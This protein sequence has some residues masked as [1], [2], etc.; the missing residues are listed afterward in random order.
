VE[1]GRLITVLVPDDGSDLELMLALRTDRGVGSVTST[2]CFESSVITQARPKHGKLPEPTL[3]RMVDVLV[4][5]EDADGVF[6]FVCGLPIID[7]H[8]GG[9]VFQHS[10]PKATFLEL[11]ADV[12]DEEQ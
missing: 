12:P 2:A 3:A 10:A 7:R 6:D 5:D 8:G 4:S 9:V 1:T 11:P